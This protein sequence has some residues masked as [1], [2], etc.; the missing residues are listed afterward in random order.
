MFALL[1]LIACAHDLSDTADTADS[2]IMAPPVV[3]AEAVPLSSRPPVDMDGDGLRFGVDCDDSDPAV[4][5]RML[6]YYDGDRDGHGA[7]GIM[8]MVCPYVPGHA[9][10]ATDC[11][12]FRAD[13]HPGAYDPAGDGVDQDCDGVDG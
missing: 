7:P 5:G 13:V 11:D 12:D 1:A 10:A 4:G 8:G 6:R 2:G 3:V 9:D